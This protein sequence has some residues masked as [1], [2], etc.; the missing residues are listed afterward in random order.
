M[1][2][3]AAGADPQVVLDVIEAAANDLGLAATR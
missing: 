1:N 2:S 3:S